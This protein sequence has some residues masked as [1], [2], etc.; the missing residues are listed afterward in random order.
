ME[1]KLRMDAVK[2]HLLLQ[3]LSCQ[4]DATEPRS[5]L[6][7]F[8]KRKS[9]VSADSPLPSMTLTPFMS[10][11]SGSSPCHCDPCQKSS[12]TFFSL[13]LCYNR[14]HTHTHTVRSLER[15]LPNTVYQDSCIPSQPSTVSDSTVFNPVEEKHHSDRERETNLFEWTSMNKPTS[16]C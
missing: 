1:M 3:H 14:T 15:P 8:V 7:Q 16:S 5:H 9:F 13:L 4:E 11:S 10:F 2:R 12:S 6:H